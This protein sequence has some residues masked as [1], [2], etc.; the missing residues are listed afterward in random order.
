MANT[1]KVNNTKK[2]STKRTG[3]TQNVHIDNKYVKKER[4]CKVFTRLTYA[5][6]IIGAV[7]YV[8]TLVTLFGAKIAP[9]H[10]WL[11]FWVQD[12]S[13]EV[14]LAP[15]LSTFAIVV[16]AFNSLWLLLCAIQF[17]GNLILHNKISLAYVPRIIIA[18]SI[19]TI[20]MLILGSC[21]KPVYAE[22]QS[23][24]YVSWMR[25]ISKADAST[26]LTSGAIIILMELICIYLGCIAYIIYYYISKAKKSKQAKQML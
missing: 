7:F 17:V 20:L 25:L 8:A 19:S 2:L 6:V 26:T 15:T 1:T 3:L 4:V 9:Y 13:E 22:G 5:N 12:F 24:F 18:L 23:E 21:C 11:G 16:I 14:V 10:F